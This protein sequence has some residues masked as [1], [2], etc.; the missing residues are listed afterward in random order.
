[1]GCASSKA[2][3]EALWHPPATGD[4]WGGAP[5]V[6]SRHPSPGACPC[7]PTA[8][9]L[10]FSCAPSSTLPSPAHSSSSWRFG[11]GMVIDKG[12]LATLAVSSRSAGDTEGP[13]PAW[14]RWHALVSLSLCSVSFSDILLVLQTHQNCCKVFVKSTKRGGPSVSSA[15]WLLKVPIKG[16]SFA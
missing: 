6:D 11:G 2:P 1:M 3:Q 13:F 12:Q 9:T 10:S 5:G 16:Q 4:G 14:G 7:S 8:S 15:A